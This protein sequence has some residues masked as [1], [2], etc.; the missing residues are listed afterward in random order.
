[1]EQEGVE[2]SREESYSS[3]KMYF[4]Y[5]LSGRWKDSLT[6]METTSPLT[7]AKFDLE[8]FECGLTVHQSLMFEGSSLFSLG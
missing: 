4:V 5:N 1:M 3:N 2:Q 6:M 8:S 7:T